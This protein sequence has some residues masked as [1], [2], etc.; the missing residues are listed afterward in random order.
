MKP[1]TS[2]D[3]PSLT[4]SQRHMWVGQHLDPASPLY[5]M[6]FTFVFEGA[7]DEACFRQAWQR[8]VDTSESLRTTIVEEAG[9]AMP[10]LLPPGSFPLE[11]VDLS[12]QTDPTAVF[13]RLAQE[14]ASRVLPIDLQLV[15]ATLARLG[16]ERFGFYLNQHH[17]ITDAAS[18][19]LLLDRLSTEY[20]NGL[21]GHLVEPPQLDD[22]YSTSRA[23]EILPSESMRQSATAHREQR[24]GD[25]DRSTPFY[26]KTIRPE[27]TRSRRLT[28]PLDESTSRR[29]RELANQEG[30]RGL[31]PDISMFTV[32]ASLLISWL[33]RISG[34]RELGFDA[35]V[36]NRLT[37]AAR[38]S[39][40][41][42]IEMFPFAVDVEEGET[43]RSLGEK[44]LAETQRFLAN[45]LPASSTQ[46][47]TT[48]ANNVVLNFFPGSF[49]NFAGIPT[50]IDWVHPGHGDRVHSLRLQV[51]DFA[52]RGQLTLQ[53][54]AN[55]EVFDRELHQRAMQHFTSL[56]QACLADP[57]QRIASIDILTDSERQAVIVD[58][59]ETAAQSAPTLPV[60]ELFREQVRLTPD[61]V[62]LRHKNRQLTFA[63][64]DRETE[65]RALQLI[66]NG[67]SPGDIVAISMHRSI[68]AVV[69]ILAT[70][71]A[72]AAYLPID[73]SYP[74]ARIRRILAD[75]GA[76][77]IL[78]ASTQ[79]LG[80][81]VAPDTV[82]ILDLDTAAD[83]HS[84]SSLPTPGLDDLAYMIYTSGSTGRPKGV[85]V[86]HS[87]LSS[88]LEWASRQ[89][90]RGDRLTFPLF[91]S[92]AFDLTVT[93]L[94]LP[95]I[96]GGTLV[97]YEEPTGP[98]DT[99]LM[100]VLGANVV[101]FIKLTPSHLSLLRE[102]DLSG[103]RIRRMVVGGEDF[104]TR[105]ARTCHR[106]FNERIEIY[107]EYGPTEAVVG[108]MV[109]RFD[110]IR[111]RESR[112]PIGSPADGVQIYV[113]NSTLTLVP[114]GVPGELCVSRFGLSE[115]YQ[116]LPELTATRFVS[117]P[118]RD[119]ER[120]YRTGDLTRFVS[121]GTLEYL[122]RIDRQLKLSGFRVEPS[123]I[124]SA[125]RA[126]PAIE[127]CVVT[128]QSH[129]SWL[130]PTPS[131][132]DYCAR[133]GLP[134]NYPDAH[135]DQEGVCSLCHAYE[136][137]RDEA[138]AYFS[139]PDT[140]REIFSASAARHD[141]P[142]DC[143]MLLSGGKDSTYALC[144][145]VDMGLKVYAFSLDNGYISEQAKDNI[146]H[147]TQTLG[148]DYELATTPAMQAIFRDSLM[149]F[150][151]VCQGCFKTIYT[152]SLQRARELGVPIVVT[153]LSRGQFFETRLTE[154]MFRG[155]GCSPQEVD[156][157]VLE[158]RKV[159]HRLDDAVSRH[160]DVEIFRQDSIFDEIQIVDFYRYWDV[161]LDELMRYLKARVQ[162]SRPSDTGRSTNCLIND[163][164]IYIHQKERGFHNYALP[165]S[166]DV[167]LGHK[168]R[169]AAIKELNDDLDREQ[170]RQMLSEIDYDENRL[171]R[172]ET[173]TGLVAFYV[174]SAR[175]SQSELRRTLRKSLPSQLVPQRFV[176]IDA[177]PMTSQG[178]I[179]YTALPSTETVG[180]DAE[181]EIT[182]LIGPVQ[183]QIAAIWR[184]LLGAG[185]VGA[186]TN[187]FDLG[188]NSLAAMEVTLQLRRQ[189]GIEIPL[190]SLFQH[191]SVEALAAHIESAII[192]EVEQMSEVEA[193]RLAGKPHEAQ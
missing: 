10:R 142:Y 21:Q 80:R 112:V 33:H 15:D 34:K 82:P 192:A 168:T 146:R 120:L 56:L 193:E 182:P 83:L 102:M 53:F 99:A 135:F 141:S 8:V 104:R 119:G 22:Y 118:F 148:V 164:G 52:G 59:N 177:M 100:D 93:S 66:A 180:V 46:S 191:P 167:R 124:E 158:A 35:P 117:H 139:D 9:I 176:Q 144:Q 75:S 136:A 50:S 74:E 186:T 111:D 140:L 181:V 143:M 123:E 58:F 65:D 57:D 17:L 90:V 91:T 185:R 61:R 159:Y 18:V 44:C 108:C 150:S 72:G 96:S 45:A 47:T 129:R 86:D 69:G 179:D 48:A 39:I 145:L 49:E 172:E 166:W 105:L 169:D 24:L 43:L 151:N 31:T 26:G 60:T 154:G 103:S 165:Y 1:S 170:I 38:A 42:F 187:F 171:V 25:L 5:N 101:D 147:V 78:S 107:N 132:L 77:L 183:E 20:C 4:L 36:H 128:E 12:E 23:L 63:E 11:V 87:G 184:Q 67:V 116:N 3:R 62:A 29:L 30:F 106:Q 137:I 70:L 14:R 190:T 97:V 175:V 71:R 88:Y 113:L 92:L 37:A 162:W 76:T 55:E 157:A 130:S 40:G 189:F 6:A 152:L 114:E 131:E 126:H 27:S 178:K 110:P 13:K 28:L 89:Y 51:H 85:R 32:L 173:R 163:V 156:R 64:L 138:K 134:S 127:D 68:E 115:G 19:V 122:G 125:L 84:R 121:P 109:H 153:G 161:G 188:G 94:F 149:R 16:Q 7:I 81:P 2:I 95:L 54:D 133:C 73:P 155:S 160:L 98:I 174:A 41:L 79:S